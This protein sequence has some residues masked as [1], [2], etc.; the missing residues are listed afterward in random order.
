M[1]KLFTLLIVPFHLFPF[2][3]FGV[4]RHVSAIVVHSSLGFTHRIRFIECPRSQSPV[5]LFFI[6]IVLFLGYF[7]AENDLSLG[8][9][10]PPEER[11]RL[12]REKNIL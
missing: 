6:D 3:L 2:K 11:C 4:S 10:T 9:W 12:V 1:L 8:V 5:P 7:A